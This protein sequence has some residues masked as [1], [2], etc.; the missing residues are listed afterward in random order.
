MIAC[1]AAGGRL[2]ATTL[3]RVPGGTLS[4]QTV[5]LAAVLCAA[6]LWSGC[7][8]VRGPVAAVPP[9]VLP[10]AAELRAVL[11]QRRE[12]VRSLRALAHIR[13]RDPEES[14]SSREAIAVARPDRLRVEVLSLFGSVFVL[15]ADDGALTAYARRDNTVYRGHAS[16][17]NLWRYVRLTLPVHDLVDL[18]LGTPP[19]RQ[20]EESRVSFDAPSGSIRLRQ[21]S[22]RGAQVVWFSPAALPL[23]AEEQGVD[24][25]TQWRARFGDYEDQNGFALATHIA[26]EVPE[27]QRSL[28]IALEDVDLNPKLDASVFAVQTPP[29]AKV[30]NLDSV[31]D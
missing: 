28:E 21:D 27:W 19:P 26:L 2:V 25:Q 9:P 6:V 11:A 14:N 4:S 7:A 8:A 1:G 31:A 13:Y 16:P 12:H 24:G 5:A 29:G 20:A 17:E 15:V 22:A 10:T 18:V 30:V 3:R 23:G